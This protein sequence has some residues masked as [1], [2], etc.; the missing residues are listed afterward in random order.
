MPSVST[1]YA[2]RRRRLPHHLSRQR[3]PALTTAESARL[4]M[5][6]IN[7][8]LREGLSLDQID[9]QSYCR[10]SAV[11]HVVVQRLTQYSHQ[12]EEITS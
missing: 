4:V 2:N 6:I 7:A 11:Y 5:Q 10:D 8:R 3:A 1:R 12:L 9:W